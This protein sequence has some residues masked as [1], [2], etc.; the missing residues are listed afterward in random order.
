MTETP[1]SAKPKTS[2]R[3]SRLLHIADQPENFRMAVRYFMEQNPEMQ[4]RVYRKPEA[5]TDQ[6]R[7]TYVDS[8][9]VP[10]VHEFYTIESALR[11]GYGP[12]DY[13][14]NFTDDFGLIYAQYTFAIG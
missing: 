1:E 8:Y 11:E 9:T 3:R 6:F 4:I 14:L 5:G 12:G 7:C 2:R 13:I 10:Q